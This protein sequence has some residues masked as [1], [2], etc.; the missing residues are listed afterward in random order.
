MVLARIRRPTEL[1]LG[2]AEVRDVLADDPGKDLVGVL[3][4]LDEDLARQEA[5]IRERRLRLRAPLDAGELP[6]SQTSVT[7]GPAGPVT[8]FTLLGRAREVR[9]VRLRPADAT[10]LVRQLTTERRLTRARTGPSS[11][12]DRPGSA[13]PAAARPAEEARRPR[14]GR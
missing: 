5:G 3:T 14:S 13:A 10:G 9:V 2:L 1:G 12:P 8:R 6:A 4:G 7:L 11:S